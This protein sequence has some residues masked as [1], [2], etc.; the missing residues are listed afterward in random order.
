MQRSIVQ[1]FYEPEGASPHRCGY[2]KSENSNVSNGMWAHQM[3]CQDYK[4]L[5]DRGWRRSGKYCYK[6]IMHRT[7]C[8]LY[9]IRCDA[10]AFQ[11]SKSQKVVMK[12]FNRY[13]EFGLPKKS[14]ASSE[15]PASPEK[16]ASPQPKGASSD[17]TSAKIPKTPKPGVGQDPNKPPCRKAKELRRERKMEKQQQDQSK[18]SCPEVPSAGAQIVKSST[19]SDHKKSIEE[20]LPNP[21]KYSAH[22]FEIKLIQ[23]SPP[24]PEFEATFK[25]SY[26]LYRKYQVSIHKDKPSEVPEKQFIRFL[27]DSPLMRSKNSQ[28]SIEYGSYHQHYYIDG[29]LVMVGVVDLL[30]NCLSSVYV[31]YDPDFMFLSPGVYS[32]LTELAAV[33]KFHK[34]DPSFHYYYMGYY[35][36]SC[37]KM[38]YKGQY[39]PSFL[40]C[41]ETY[42]WVPIEKC[43]DKLSAA[44]YCHFEEDPEVKPLAVDSYIGQTLLLYERQAMP[45]SIFSIIC[46]N[47]AEHKKIR[48]YA[49]LAGKDVSSRMLLYID[50]E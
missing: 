23:S 42:R 30:P 1:Y 44:K 28:D 8:P 31:F 46:H 41:P 37:Q 9:A 50:F 14:E 29:K 10:A 4:D 3:T 38:K 27:V 5:I 7:C 19:L 2:C 15:N 17:G 36:H 21:D 24:S 20:L 45:Y 43:K 33:R 13:L 12:K 48:E 47:E 16:P 35:V 25:E 34:T 11:L 22:K 49:E 40:V 39:T 32:A 18:E 6:P 26:A